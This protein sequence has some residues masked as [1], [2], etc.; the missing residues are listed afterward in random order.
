VTLSGFVRPFTVIE[1]SLVTLTSRGSGV[2]YSNAVCIANVPH[3]SLAI[4]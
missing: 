4:L 1:S 2:S 3:E